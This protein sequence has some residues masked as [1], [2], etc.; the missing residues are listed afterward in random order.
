MPSHFNWTL[1]HSSTLFRKR[2]DFQKNVVE[3]EVSGFGF[4]LQILSGT[5]FIL[6]G[7]KGDVINVHSPCNVAGI[8]VRF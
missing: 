3:H 7:I 2:H 6:K 4:L 8:V 1:P 5:F